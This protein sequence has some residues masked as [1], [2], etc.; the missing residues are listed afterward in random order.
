M[1]NSKYAFK[2]WPVLGVSIAVQQQQHKLYYQ[3]KS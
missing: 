2:L 1:G 3:I